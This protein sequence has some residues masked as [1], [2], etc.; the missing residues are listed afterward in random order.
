MVSPAFDESALDL[1]EPVDPPPGD[2]TELA[3][4]P[5]CLVTFLGPCA[6][7]HFW[8]LNWFKNEKWVNMTVMTERICQR[9]CLCLKEGVKAI[10]RYRRVYSKE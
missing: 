4:G 9:I 5:C 1:P 8:Y 7:M 10:I 6:S 2:V 3:V